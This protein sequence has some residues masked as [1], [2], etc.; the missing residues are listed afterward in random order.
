MING[1]EAYAFAFLGLLRWLEKPTVIKST[2][3]AIKESSGGAVW[4][5]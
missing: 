2:T 1:K 5:P 4:L 3:G